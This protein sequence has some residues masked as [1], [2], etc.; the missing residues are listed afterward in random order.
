VAVDAILPANRAAINLETFYWFDVPSGVSKYANL[1]Y[2]FCYGK[3]AENALP[4]SSVCKTI[5]NY[6]CLARMGRR[7]H[8]STLFLLG[9]LYANNFERKESGFGLNL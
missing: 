6:R 8:D 5:S 7:P 9:W 4:R 2:F 1:R 3:R